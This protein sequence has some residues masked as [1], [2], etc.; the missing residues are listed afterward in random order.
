MWL[1]CHLGVNFLGKLVFTGHGLS[2]KLLR[3]GTSATS[4][5]A[6]PTL[7]LFFSV[8]ECPPMCF[9][10]C[11]FACVFNLFPMDN[12]LRQ[13]WTTA[14]NELLHRPWHLQ[15]CTPYQRYRTFKIGKSIGLMKKN[16][17]N[18]KS[19]AEHRLKNAKAAKK[20]T[21]VLIGMCL[22][23]FIRFIRHSFS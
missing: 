20:K 6:K 11:F 3:S 8:T 19:K 2:S 16:P 14:R 12:L 13:L 23:M 9:Q 5:R 1:V 15:K 7:S 22:S 17:R 21:T 10:H 18:G 4:Q